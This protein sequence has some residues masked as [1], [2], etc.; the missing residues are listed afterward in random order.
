MTKKFVTI[1]ELPLPNPDG[2]YL[3]EIRRYGWKEAWQ[4]TRRV[5]EY[6]AT[7]ERAEQIID[8]IGI[9]KFDIDL[10]KGKIFLSASYGGAS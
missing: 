4:S 6:N 2:L 5:S 3:V 10:D 8:I 1:T 9:E 7:R